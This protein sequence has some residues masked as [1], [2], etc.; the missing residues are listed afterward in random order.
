MAIITISE[1]AESLGH[2]IALKIS[3]RIGFV[4]VDTDF[5]ISKLTTYQNLDEQS[6][7]ERVVSGKINSDLIKKL[8]VEEA[9]RNNVVIHNLGAEILFRNLPGTLHVGIHGSS[10]G[11]GSLQEKKDTHSNILKGLYGRKR[12]TNNLYD[13]QVKLE[14]MNTD[15][16]VELIL[17]AVEIN[18]ITA[19]P[20]QTWK[21][22]KKM[23]DGFNKVKT[24]SNSDND[25]KQLDVP[26]F[27]HPSEKGFAGVLDFYRIKWEYEPKSFP[28]AWN[29]KGKPVEEFTPDFYLP[30]LDLYI[31]LTTQKQKLVTK[32]NRKVR[33]LKEL[34]PNV[35]L[36]I[37]YGKDYKKLVQRFGIKKDGPK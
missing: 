24:A 12:L 33:K 3:K 8:I 10:N 29:E 35:N 19:K 34:Y 1:K 28:I 17:K 14:N 23:K 20:G 16:V 18:S 22:L 13:I 9:F 6:L 27:A 15:Y 26:L 7:A 4:L 32:K 36:K 30:D 25:V 37:F 21:A 31:E 11:K 5:I 2:E